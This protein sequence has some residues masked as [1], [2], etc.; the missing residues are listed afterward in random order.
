MQR[1]GFDEVIANPS[2]VAFGEAMREVDWNEMF[3]NPGSTIEGLVPTLANGKASEETKKLAAELSYVA[4]AVGAGHAPA[5]SVGT[6]SPG[7]NVVCE[8]VRIVLV[9]DH[10]AVQDV[11]NGINISAGVLAA[12][13]AATGTI[14]AL[15]GLAGLVPASAVTA[16]ITGVAG[17]SSAFLAASAGLLGAIDRGHGIYVTITIPQFVAAALLIVASIVSPLTAF[18]TLPAAAAACVPIPTTRPPS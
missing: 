3:R 5:Q 11:I 10:S 7:V 14:S 9:L 18:I 1:A 16:V 13:A 4:A 8:D 12:F 2:L 15:T 6:A 17:F